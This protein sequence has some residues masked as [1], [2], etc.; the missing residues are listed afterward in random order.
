MTPEGFV[1]PRLISK[2]CEYHRFPRLNVSRA[3]LEGIIASDE[4]VSYADFV[5]RI[6]DLYGEREGK[7]LVGDKTT[8]GYVRNLSTLNALWPNAPFVHLI[9]DGRD[10]CLSMLHWPKAHRAAGRF[11]VWKEDPVSTAA[12]WWKWDVQLGLEGGRPLGPDLNHQIRYESLVQNPADECV[13]LCAFLG[14]P[15]DDAMVKFHEGRTKPESGLSA[16]RAWLPPTPGIRDWRSH[17]PAKD[18]ERIEA[19][20]PGGLRHRNRQSR[21]HP[22][23]EVSR[24]PIR[25]GAGI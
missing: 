24:M 18:V 1:T 4:P 21:S 14:L 7:R 23:P 9:R 3:E 10:V 19:A 22:V 13:A 6:F 25:C 5:S 15:Y 12:L 16:N 11:S 17:M 8:G 2:L 20:G